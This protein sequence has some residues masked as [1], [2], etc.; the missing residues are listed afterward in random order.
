M[1]GA[2]RGYERRSEERMMKETNGAEKSKS[3]RDGEEMR[4]VER[5]GQ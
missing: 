5:G 3:G 1:R 4:G 2:P